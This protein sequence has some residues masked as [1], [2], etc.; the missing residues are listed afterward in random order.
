[1]GDE[2]LSTSSEATHS[3]PKNL[4]PLARSKSWPDGRFTKV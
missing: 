2:K 3:F 1:M 4:R